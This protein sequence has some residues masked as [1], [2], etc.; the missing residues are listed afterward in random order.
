MAV[1]VVPGENHGREKSPHFGSTKLRLANF[2]KN[3][4]TSPT[5]ARLGGP[6]DVSAPAAEN[7]Q[8]S[9]E[10][11][12]NGSTTVPECNAISQIS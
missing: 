6:A 9:G 3:R 8:I 4:P 12:N 1:G 2:L 11:K 7:L 10:R 5:D